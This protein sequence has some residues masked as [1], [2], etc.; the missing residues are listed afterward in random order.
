M[1]MPEHDLGNVEIGDNPV[2]ERADGFDV[3]GRSA[4][5]FFRFRTYRQDLFCSPCVAVN[6][7]DGRLT[8]NYAFSFCIDQRIRCAQVYRQIVG[9]LPQNEI[10]QQGRTSWS[11]ALE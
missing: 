11:F 7:H 10:K 6:G 9:K 1:K 5:H 4:E 3:A 8:Q 2:P